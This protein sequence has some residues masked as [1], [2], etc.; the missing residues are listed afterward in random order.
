M[1]TDELTQFVR[2]WLEAW[3]GNRPQALLGYYAADAYYQDPARPRGLRGRDAI[4]QYFARL[5]SANPK[6]VWELVELLP[7]EKGCCVKWKATVPKPTGEI[8]FQGLDIVELAGRE[9]T[10]N[11]VY[12]DPSVLRL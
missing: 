11:E 3:T 9:I 12:F 4:G 5:L 2:Q 10:R 8:S 7:T 1:Q 6:W